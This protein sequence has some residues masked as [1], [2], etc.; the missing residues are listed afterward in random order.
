M[1]RSVLKLQ[2]LFGN[3]KVKKKDVSDYK[4]IARGSY[5]QF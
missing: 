1:L 2:T 5:M 4:V 3:K